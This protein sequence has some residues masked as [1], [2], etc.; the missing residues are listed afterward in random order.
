M[1]APQPRGNDLAATIKNALT[2][3]FLIVQLYAFR[4]FGDSVHVHYQIE[5][6]GDTYSGR[7]GDGKTFFVAWLG[8]GDE[9]REPSTGFRIRAGLIS[10][11]HREQWGKI[12]FV[13]LIATMPATCIGG[14]TSSQSQESCRA[15]FFIFYFQAQVSVAGIEA[16]LTTVRA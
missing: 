7:G 15:I 8:P 12:D 6:D 16:E 14:D 9:W 5:S 1:R 4:P 2:T 13:Y 3:I 10:C 11:P